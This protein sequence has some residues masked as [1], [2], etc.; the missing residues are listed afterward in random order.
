ML[1]GAFDGQGGYDT[2]YASAY[3]TPRAFYLSALLGSTDGFNGTESSILG[4][5]FNIQQLIGSLS[6]NSLASADF[7]ARPGCRRH[8]Q[9]GHT[10]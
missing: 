6:V 3:T 9:S 8:P 5:F 10:G 4:G 2:I 1:A 7:S